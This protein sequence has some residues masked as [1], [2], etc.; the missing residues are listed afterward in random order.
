MFHYFL[1]LRKNSEIGSTISYQLQLNHQIP[2]GVY[3]LEFQ[4]IIQS[5]DLITPK[6]NKAP[7]STSPTKPVFSVSLLPTVTTFNLNVLLLITHHKTKSCYSLLRET[8][9][10][11]SF[12]IVYPLSLA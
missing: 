11:S 10:F 1:F 3:I 8:E 2:L 5:K 7:C 4:E 6:L 12:L 9:S